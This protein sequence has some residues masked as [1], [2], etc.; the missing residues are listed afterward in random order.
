MPTA[1]FTERYYALYSIYSGKYGTVAVGSSEWMT[2]QTRDIVG[3]GTGFHDQ[4]VFGR[5]RNTQSVSERS[6]APV[7]SP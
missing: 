2:M 7:H 6:H 4:Q 5:V 3:G 1:D